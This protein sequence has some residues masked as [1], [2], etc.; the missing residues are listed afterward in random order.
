[1]NITDSKSCT[2]IILDKEKKNVTKYVRVLLIITLPLLVQCGSGKPDSK[3]PMHNQA[4]SRYSQQP[5]LIPEIIPQDSLREIWGDKYYLSIEECLEL[6]NLENSYF[7]GES[8]RGVAV[9]KAEKLNKL[10]VKSYAVA[11]LRERGG[12]GSFYL[13]I[14]ELKEP[15][16]EASKNRIMANHV[17]A[18]LRHEPDKYKSKDEY[19]YYSDFYNQYFYYD[20]KFIFNLQSNDAEDQLRDALLELVRG[21][22][23]GQ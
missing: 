3:Q 2:D 5:T 10:A 23:S 12:S 6:P 15:L 21:Y 9:D 7:E 22:A 17:H 20:G 8:I 1:M 19:L 4:N 11:W 13:E 16:D 14:A 18:Y